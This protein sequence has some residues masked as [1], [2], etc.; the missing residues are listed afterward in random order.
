MSSIKFAL[1]GAFIYIAI[2]LL[3]RL[4]ILLCAH[5]FGSIGVD[6][7]RVHAYIFF[8]LIWI[9]S[10]AIAYRISPPFPQIPK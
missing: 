8:L 5:F 6:T 9:V 1:L 3:L 4:A 10:F 7:T 2:M